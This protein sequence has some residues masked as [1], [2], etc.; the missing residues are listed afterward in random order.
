MAETDHLPERVLGLLDSLSLAESVDSQALAEKFGQD[1][2]K[3]VG[4]IKSL[5]ALGEEH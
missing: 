1:H 4:A 3:I 2:Q 5:E